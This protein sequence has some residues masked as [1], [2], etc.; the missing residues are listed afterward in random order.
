MIDFFHSAIDFTARLMKTTYGRLIL[1]NP[2]QVCEDSSFVRAVGNEIVCNNTSYVEEGKLV[3]R[4]RL[5]WLV[6]RV[7][8]ASRV[9]Q[10]GILE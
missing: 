9:L 3:E 4:N 5:R 7:M 8:V 1:Q 10:L 2:R 6:Y